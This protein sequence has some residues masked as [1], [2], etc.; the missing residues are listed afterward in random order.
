MKRYGLIGEKLSHSFSKEIHE[1]IADY[2]YDL[3]PLSKEEF[4]KFMEQRDFTAIN[5][6]IPY[7]KDVIPYLDE[8]DDAAKQIGAVNTI[9]NRDGKLKG[10]NTDYTGFLYMVKKHH[11]DMEGKKVLVIGNG[12]AS[13]A[14]RAAVAHEKAAS[15]IVVDIIVGNGAISYEECLEKHLDAQIIINTSPVGMYPKTGN[16]PIDLSLFH[17]LESVMDVVYNPLTTKLALEAKER[18]LIAVNGLEMLVAQAKQAV[19]HFLDETIND[20]VIDQIYRNLYQE[21]SNIIL[22]GMPS[23][24]KTT[25]GQCI[26]EKSHKEL[27]DMDAYIVE[28]EGKSIPA[29]FEEGGEPLFRAK[30]TQAAITLSKYNGKVIATGGGIIKHKINM[31]Y[32]KQNGIVIFID[33]SL[34]YLVGSDATRPLCSS[35]DAVAQMYEERIDLYRAYADYIVDNNSSLQSCVDAIIHILQLKEKNYDYIH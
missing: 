10:Y 8:I 9:V 3:I 7:K 23:A 31:D 6:T 28:K 35:K 33:R 16:S 24:G 14:I 4:P 5:V 34:E 25:I 20:E 1:A 15:M 27:I 13:A 26:A 30:E 2:T 29:I 22:I 18:G 11:V 17:R 21:R 32:L 12:G 19:E